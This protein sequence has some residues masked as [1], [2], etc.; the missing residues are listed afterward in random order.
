MSLRN[1]H[2]LQ[3]P[4]L[5]GWR[6]ASAEVQDG[7]TTFIREDGADSAALSFSS[8]ID[9][10][11]SDPP[12]TN[13][14]LRRVANNLAASGSLLLATED[15]TC[16]FGRYASSTYRLDAHTKCQLWVLS[17]GR[18][19]I[20]ATLTAS[21]EFSDKLRESVLQVIMSTTLVETKPWYR[22]W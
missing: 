6:D 20:F 9:Q 17:D 18:N 10:V 13:E 3:L 4:L 1:R 2:R 16:Q 7:P 14:A 22:F 15:G 12:L 5:E 8:A 21:D 19:L 11:P